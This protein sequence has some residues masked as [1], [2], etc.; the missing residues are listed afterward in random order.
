M[1]SLKI[2]KSGGREYLSIVSGYWDPINKRSR[3]K[4]IESLGYLDSLKEQYDDP[5]AHFQKVVDELNKNLVKEELFVKLNKS[6]QLSDELN[7]LKNLGYFALSAIYHELGL[8]LLFR[9]RVN[10]HQKVDTSFT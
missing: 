10:L 5:I 1:E 7:N 8:D 2:G 3:T 4:T 6:S 9:N